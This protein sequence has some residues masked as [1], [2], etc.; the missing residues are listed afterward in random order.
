MLIVRGNAITKYC[1]GCKQHK[2]ITFF[3][4][5]KRSEDGFFSYCK[6]CKNSRDR[7]YWVKYADKIREDRAK[8][9]KHRHSKGLCFYCDNPKLAH[10]NKCEKCWFAYAANKR[11]GKKN[12]KNGNILKQK[13]IDQNYKCPYSG[14]KLTPG[15][16][17]ELDHIKPVSRFPLLAH[18]INNVE[19]ID[20]EVNHAKNNM[21]K[22][23]FI[24]MCK[25]IIDNQKQ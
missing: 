23:E 1:P 2:D 9:S 17:C 5:S 16:N 19:W 15:I 7:L 3:T 10:A 4:K 22:E 12:Y 6:D 20:S 18:D 24:S 21:T 13:L 14:R 25:E 11:L 8:L